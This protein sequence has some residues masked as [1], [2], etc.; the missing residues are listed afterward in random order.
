MIGVLPIEIRDFLSLNELSE[1]IEKEIIWYET[2]FKDYSERLGSILR[3]E[4]LSSE[5]IEKILQEKGLTR[6][7]ASN[8][9]KKRKASSSHGWLS[10]KGLLFSADKNAQAE[11]LFES[12]E[13]AEKT[14]N[15][16]K[17]IRTLIEELQKIGL[18]SNLA[19]SVYFI[20]GVPE[21][22]FIQKV[23]NAVHRYKLELFLSTS[24]EFQP[25]STPNDETV[26]TSEDDED[27]DEDASKT[28]ENLGK[29][30]K[31]ATNKNEENRSDEKTS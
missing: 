24:K 25:P 26:K 16:M 9:G 7:A 28:K 14:I 30:P 8:K 27:I 21:K 23:G 2:L 6:R 15:K 31:V 13:K 19:F 1:F 22:I 4:G 17:E 3:E 20:D 12:I 11:I 29:I 10:Y 5:E 18:G